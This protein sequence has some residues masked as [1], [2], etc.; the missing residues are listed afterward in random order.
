MLYTKLYE[1]IY[2]LRLKITAASGE[3]FGFWPNRIYLG[4]TIVLQAVSWWL[5]YFVFKNLSSDLLVL[6]YNVDFGIDWVGDKNLIFYFPLLGLLFFILSVAMLYVFGP[7][8]HF[9]FQ[10]HYLMLGNVLANLGMLTALLL[11]YLI[12][13]R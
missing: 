6:H 12:N 13:F 10:S 4:V 1:R 5:S 9:R 7:G 11:I 2:S 3:F 8:R